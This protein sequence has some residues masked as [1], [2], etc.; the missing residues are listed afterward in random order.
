MA[1]STSTSS[2]RKSFKYRSSSSSTSPF[3]KKKKK[4]FKYHV[5][6][7][8]SEEDMRNTTFIHQLFEA[9]MV[10][11]ICTYYKADDDDD[12][13]EKLKQLIEESK[14][15]IIVFS[16]NYASSSY[17]LN[18]LVKIAECQDPPPILRLF[19]PSTM[20]I[21]HGISCFVESFFVYRGEAKTIENIVENILL[22]LSFTNLW[23]DVNL[24]GM[25]ARVKDVVSL[26]ETGFNNA[27][28]I[29][30]KG[31]GGIGKTTL[32][33]TIYGKIYNQFE[34]SSFVEDVRE[35]SRTS[36]LASLQKKILSDVLHDEDITVS[37]VLDGKSMMKEKLHC[38]KVLLV[39][40]DVDHIDQLQALAGAPDWFK[41]GSIIIVTTRDEQV[42]VAH[43]VKC[44]HTVEC[45]FNE[46]A[47]YLFSRHAFGRDIPIQGYR[48]LSLQFVSYTAGIP[49]TIK[50]MGSFLCGKKE[51][52]WIDTLERLKTIPLAKIPEEI[53]EL[54]YNDLEVDCKEVFLDVAC[55]LKGLPVDSISRILERPGIQARDALR[56]LEKKS[57]ITIKDHRY[58]VMHPLIEAVGKAIDRCV[59]LDDSNKHSRLWARDEI[60]YVLAQNLGNEATIAIAVDIPVK[61]CS[62]VVTKGFGS[63]KNLRLLQVVSEIDDDYDEKIGQI[64]LN[65]P[66]VLRFLSWKGYPHWSLPKTFL[67]NSL[68]VLEM[69]YSRIVQLWEGGERTIL[70]KLKFLNLRHSRLKTLDLGLTPNLERLDLEDCNHLVDLHIPHVGYLE[71]LMY[72]NLSGCSRVKKSFPEKGTLEELECRYISLPVDIYKEIFLHVACLLKGFQKEDVIRILGTCYSHVKRALSVIEIADLI[73]IDDHQYVVMHPHIEAMGKNIVCRDHPDKPNQRFLLWIR[74]EIEYVLANDLGTEATKAI[75]VGGVKLTSE[76]VTK[77]FESMKG[78]ELLHIVSEIDD[79]KI[80]QISLNFPNGLR[81][82][83]WEGY[84]HGYLP[85]TFNADNLVALEMPYSRIIQL[86][87]GEETKTLS[88]LNFLNLRHT[89][90]RTLDLDMSPYLVRLELEGCKHLV[91]LLHTVISCL[92]FLVYLNLSGCLGIKSFVFIKE[93]RSLQI[94]SLSDL[95]LKEFPDIIPGHCDNGLLELRFRHND[96]EEVPSSIENLRMLVRLDFHSC[97]KLRSLPD[98][99]CGLQHLRNL[100]LYGCSTL[101]ELPQDVG[102]LGCLEKLNLSYTSIK[103]LPDSICKLGNLKTLKLSFCRSLEKLPRDLGELRCLEK[104]VL[105]ECTQVKDVPDS[106]C[107]LKHLKYLNLLDC[108]KL[109][110]LPKEVGN[111]VSLEVLNVK[112]T[113]IRQLPPSISKLI[114]LE[115]HAPKKDRSC[116]N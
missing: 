23:V 30:I 40:D 52:Q 53:L 27:F 9:L 61:L 105:M 76:I 71:R 59:H 48:E 8:F 114:H 103:H 101:E 17:C 85:K 100:K 22:G 20:A 102:C 115:I 12:D 21:I 2:I 29:G 116:F 33:K 66:Y 46:E 109:E 36:G 1:S 18:E 111:L 26:L 86:W 65:F 51:H 75:A 88:R 90:L 14:F 38:K 68:V 16:K 47:I 7:S 72:A 84:P 35:V 13:D 112:G 97:R 6:V 107:R 70:Y 89:Q 5:Y 62:E 24:V 50:V 39:L 93:L 78:L 11:G 28:T 73:S 37:S 25:E 4:R 83:S 45:L 96:I 67:G 55:L 49:L 69:P 15:F 43:G 110:K 63:M 87:E 54:S 91:E 41:P 79:E 42:L 106:I 80:G 94:L 108:C 113:R 98:S 57:L 104:L 44:I 32:A 77:G 81:F 34:E 64:R 60:E 99:I 10:E 31:I 74:G 3:E 95:Y 58:V 56:I 19:T 82:L 92:R